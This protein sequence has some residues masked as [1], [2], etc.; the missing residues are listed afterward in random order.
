MIVGPFRRF[1][2]TDGLLEHINS[3]GIE[4]PSRGPLYTKLIAVTVLTLG[5]GLLLAPRISRNWY[6]KNKAG[7]FLNVQDSSPI[8]TFV[9]AA[10]LPTAVGLYRQFSLARDDRLATLALSAA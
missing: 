5:L 2:Y 10:T 7:L 1:S 4:Q 9:D 6:R 8:V 3:S